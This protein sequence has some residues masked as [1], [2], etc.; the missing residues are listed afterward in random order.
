MTNY[1]MTVG[2]EVHI[3]LNTKSKMFCSCPVQFGGE[4]N[5]RICPVCTGLPGT[6]PR[7]NKRAIEFA[8]KAGLAT[9]CKISHKS[10]MARKNYY[11]PDL[12]KAFQISQKDPPLCFDGSIKIN[13]KKGEKTIRISRIHIEEDA[14]KLIHDNEQNTLIDYNR[15]GTPL[16]E[17]VS[18]P[19]IAS[20]DEAKAY[21]KALRTRILYTDISDCKM[22]EG[23]MR[24][25][26]NVSVKE[27][28]SDKL[29]ERVEIKNINSIAF[30][31][32]AIDAEFERMVNL[33]KNG[34]KIERETRRYNAQSGKTEPMR[35]KEDIADYRFFTEPDIL[36][37]YVSEDLI[38]KMNSELPMMPE[39][40]IQRYINELELS[41]YDASLL[42][43]DK[44]LSNAYDNAAELT[45]HKKVLAN[46]M[47]GEILRLCESE[48]FFCPI[49][50]KNLAELADLIG[51]GKISHT[52][53][54]KMIGRIW[55]SDASPD[56]IAQKENLYQINDKDFLTE[57][58]KDAIKANQRSIDDYKKGKKNALKAVM[59]YIMAKT[60][61]LANPQIAESILLEFA[62]K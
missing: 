50:A 43:S 22:N 48:D 17:I 51:E 9:N 12:P 26:V 38:E 6:L 14:G 2:L 60:K 58:V 49:S 40:K 27:K 25:D 35:S 23:S 34:E 5:S 11:Y 30:V 31:G 20:G 19:D 33:L 55:E 39:E 18:A 54:K 59:G 46:L 13:T 41:E 62:E 1:E 4:P 61:G 53:A 3:E 32:K 7:I 8:I 29:G 37:I 57:L 45:S 42:S 44:S 15:C 47:L 28:G 56:E 52:T 24:C 10:E 36:P 16:I 21:L